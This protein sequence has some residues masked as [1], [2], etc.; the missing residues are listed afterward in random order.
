MTTFRI[1]ADRFLPAPRMVAASGQRQPRSGRLPSRTV[2]HRSSNDG[3]EYSNG[4]EAAA[5]S[6]VS[7]AQFRCE[8]AAKARPATAKARGMPDATPAATN[9]GQVETESEVGRRVGGRDGTASWC[10]EMEV[11]TNRGR[12]GRGGRLPA[13]LAAARRPLAAAVENEGNP[14]PAPG[15]VPRSRM[16]WVWVPPR[17]SLPPTD[18]RAAVQYRPARC[19]PAAPTKRQA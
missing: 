19:R 11:A 5:A 4:V 7:A 17:S 13:C 12:P 1:E 15:S 8:P 6:S 16:P 10:G 18:S 2:N 14:A 3:I 9:R